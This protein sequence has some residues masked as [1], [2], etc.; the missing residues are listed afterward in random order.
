MD[1]FTSSTSRGR[2]SERPDT[3]SL[4]RRG[5]LEHPSVRTAFHGI[6]H[7]RE[8]GLP[9][10]P[11]ALTG[12]EY[13]ALLGHPVPPNALLP[14]M[15]TYESAD[16]RWAQLASGPLADAI[17]SGLLTVCPECSFLSYAAVPCQICAEMLDITPEDATRSADSFLEDGI[18]HADALER[19]IMDW[20]MGRA[21]DLFDGPDDAVFCAEAVSAVRVMRARNH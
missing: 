18:I 16:E 12:A 21:L 9:P 13:V 8:S 3:V 7:L 1:H 15:N 10:S 20:R 5:F 4:K 17:D 2:A 6:A 11:L 14:T 19:H